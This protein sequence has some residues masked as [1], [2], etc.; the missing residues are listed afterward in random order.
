[1]ATIDTSKVF[2]TVKQIALDELR[3]KGYAPNSADVVGIAKL[4]AALVIAEVEKAMA[5]VS[6]ASQP[7]TFPSTSSSV[8]PPTELTKPPV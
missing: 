1:M 3:A 5:E 7:K 6:T 8:V 2:E 4:S